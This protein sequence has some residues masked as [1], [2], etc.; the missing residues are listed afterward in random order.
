MEI[1]GTQGTGADLALEFERATR[2]EYWGLGVWVN[3]FRG[4]ALQTVGKRGK[5]PFCFIL[6]D[7]AHHLYFISTEIQLA[8]LENS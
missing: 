5:R 1:C 8:C 6:D 2:N 7:L 4:H 3:I